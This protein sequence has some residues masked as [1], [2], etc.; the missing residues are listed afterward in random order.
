MK[1]IKDGVNYFTLTKEDNNTTKNTEIINN[2]AK[3]EDKYLERVKEYININNAISIS[4]I[5]SEFAIGYPKASKIMSQL[6]EEGL[7]KVN[8]DGSYT[9]IR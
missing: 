6:I 9:I 2:E 7:V 5:Q 8:A 1:L 3:K 4:R